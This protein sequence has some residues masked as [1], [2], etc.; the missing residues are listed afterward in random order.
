MKEIC[1]RARYDWVIALAASF[2]IL[3][4][5]SVTFDGGSTRSW[6]LVGTASQV[7]FGCL[8]RTR[9]KKRASAVVVGL[10]AVVP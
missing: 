5:G 8:L 3:E 7:L 1:S 2:P 4:G 10:Y 6:G 9:P